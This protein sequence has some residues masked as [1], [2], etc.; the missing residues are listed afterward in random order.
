MTSIT[1]ILPLVH[2]ID[3]KLCFLIIDYMTNEDVWGKQVFSNAQYSYVKD[4]LASKQRPSV[5]CYPIESH[6]NNNSYFLTGTIMLELHFSL[7]YKRKELAEKVIQIANL[8]W[9]IN[10]NGDFMEYCQPRM[11]GLMFLGKTASVDYTKVYDKESVVKFKFEYQIDQMVYQLWLQEQ[12][13]DTT[14][15]NEIIYQTAQSLFEQIALL[16]LELEPVIIT[17]EEN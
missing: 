13:Y 2:G 15:P 7:Q 8:I 17:T 10:L 14:S 9:L 5:F 16:N 4:D 11:G 1:Q 12:G 3:N 6:K